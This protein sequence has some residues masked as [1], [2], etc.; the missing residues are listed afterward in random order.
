MLQLEDLRLKDG[1]T[2]P[3]LG[4]GTWFLGEQFRYQSREL[5]AI[6]R[7]LE[8]GIRM[9]DTAEMYGDGGAE[10]IVGK[11]IQDADRA[12]LYLVSKV[13]PHNATSSK[14]AESCAETLARL[15]TKYLDLYLLHWRGGVPLQET[16]EGMEAL[17]ARGKIKRWGVSNF[18]VAD[19]EALFSVK[20]GD[21]CVV[22]QVMYHLGSRGIEHSLLPWMKAHGVAH[23]AYSPLA[24]G[25][26]LK[27]ELVSHPVIL[28]VCARNRIN[29]HQLML[30]F[31]LRNPQT[32]AIPRSSNAAHVDDLIKGLYV[33]LSE[34]DW[35]RLEEAFPAPDHK[36]TLDV[37]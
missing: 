17:V 16:V 8:Q 5:Q 26:A 25:G 11:A 32:I 33:T 9:I 28:S 15:G 31:A 13:Y 21:K 12:Q 24:Q 34:E 10:T 36:V 3:R 4:L 27:K 19:M 1:S 20:G 7:G 14:I 30:L 37:I 23:M 29:F 35:T 6:K 2:I 22:N 18:D